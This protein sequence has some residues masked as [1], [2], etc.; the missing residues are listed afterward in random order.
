LL[1]EKYIEFCFDVVKKKTLPYTFF[2]SGFCTISEDEFYCTSEKGGPSRYTFNENSNSLSHP[3][4]FHPY[5]LKRGHQ[6]S[7]LLIKSLLIDACLKRMNPENLYPWITFSVEAV[8]QKKAWISSDVGVLV[9]SDT[10]KLFSYAKNGLMPDICEAVNSA[11]SCAQSN[12]TAKFVMNDRSTWSRMFYT[13]S[14][15]IS[16]L[17]NV[18]NLKKDERIPK[19]VWRS[20]LLR[21]TL[22]AYP[23]ELIRPLKKKV[24][25]MVR[26]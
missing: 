26:R 12:E 15:V 19:D 10:P 23:L 22:L 20:F 6:L 25:S 13:G 2:A 21:Y 4:L 5:Y 9:T 8:L 16:Q 24:R 7:G 1:S 11:P 14:N 17:R 3:E 18:W